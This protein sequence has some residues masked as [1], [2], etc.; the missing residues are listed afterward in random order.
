MTIYARVSPSTIKLIETYYYEKYIDSNESL[1]EKEAP[2][3]KIEVIIP[4][5]GH[6]HFNQKAIQDVA[7]QI[8]N[9]S[10]EKEVQALI[11]HLVISNYDKTDL[12]SLLSENQQNQSVP[13]LIPVANNT[14]SKI[15]QLG[16]DKHLCIIEYDYRPI[17]PE[18]KPIYLEIQVLDDYNDL[19]FSQEDKILWNSSKN[20]ME[21]YNRGDLV[22][23][24][25]DNIS[26]KIKSG[27]GVDDD[28]LKGKL[29]IE[30]KVRLALP[31]E[32]KLPE[33]P[34]IKRLSI[35]WP[36]LT[37]FRNFG[38][39]FIES[40]N[41]S[42]ENNVSN[43]LNI[44]YNPLTKSLEW[45]SQSTDALIT[46]LKQAEL[47]NSN[48][49]WQNYEIK[50]LLGIIQPGELYQEPNL[51]GEIEIEIP[52]LLLSGLQTRFY[53]FNNNS[54]SKVGEYK[55]EYSEFK[56]RIVTNFNLNLNEAF[57]KRIRSTAQEFIFNN[58]LPT[59]ENLR[60][61]KNVLKSQGF[62]SDSITLTP[63]RN[64]SSNQSNSQINITE[65]KWLIYAERSEGI[66]TMTLWIVIPGEEKKTLVTVRGKIEYKQEE[67][68]G[69]L[70]MYLLGKLPRRSDIL[71]QRMNA[72]QRELRK[73]LERV[74]QGP[75]TG[76]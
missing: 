26:R 43:P 65:Q 33:L 6:K 17:T 74:Q 57:K 54:N 19:R 32:F 30:I 49:Q 52:D 55:K 18:F 59:E 7:K 1:E 16:E 76:L 2:K 5:D 25:A 4:Y 29:F 61:I 51:K 28:L 8:S 42:T 10:S 31:I 67:T 9:S 14:L 11:G 22:N 62:S 46:K 71:I 21:Q 12:E 35:E 53:G 75:A 40:Q 34:R 73:Q 27:F 38:L 64:Q 56:S 13:L 45:I 20:L 70:T 37:S 39:N 36:T 72:L 47:E 69:K 58:V 60:I 63:S 66:D 44:V 24:I 15:K 48:A 50:M 23:N 41:T 3:G 68:T